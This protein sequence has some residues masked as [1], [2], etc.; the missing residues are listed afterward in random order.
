M[1][2]DKLSAKYLEGD[3][4][5]GSDNTCEVIAA[6]NA[7]LDVFNFC[8]LDSLDQFPSMLNSFESRGIV[9]SGY[10]GTS[11]SAIYKYF[12]QIY[13]SYSKR[14]KKARIGRLIGRRVNQKNLDK[15][16]KEY[17]SFILMSYNDASDMGD[18]IHTICISKLKDCF[19]A[20]NDYEGCRESK[21]LYD[22]V[23]GYNEYKSKPLVIIGL[24]KIDID[25]C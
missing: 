10:F 4:L 13:N 12:K 22:A 6:F 15:Y 18:M 24:S 8:G 2:K 5:D 23:F 19:K 11:S 21:S 20:H 3:K 9:K 14:G 7:S 25:F 17:D 16:E 1:Q